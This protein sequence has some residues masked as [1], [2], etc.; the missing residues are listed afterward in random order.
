MQNSFTHERVGFQLFPPLTIVDDL[1]R[2]NHFFDLIVV[3]YPSLLD[4][5]D[6]TLSFVV[7]LETSHVP[8]DG[9]YFREF[10]FR[11]SIHTRK[12]VSTLSAIIRG[13]FPSRIWDLSDSK[14][15]PREIEDTQLEF[16]ENNKIRG[17]NEHR[18]G[19]RICAFCF[20]RIYPSCPVLCE[21]CSRRSYCSIECMHRDSDPTGEG[22]GHSIWCS[23]NVCEEGE[24]WTV[25][26]VPGKGLGV[27]AKKFIASR[28]RILVDKPRTITFR[29]VRDLEPLEGPLYRK[30]R[31]NS[32]GVSESESLLCLRVAR[33][34]HDC[35]P[36]ASQVFDADMG[37]M[38]VVANR[39]IAAEE[40]ICISYLNSLGRNGSY[41]L[42]SG[43]SLLMEKWGIRCPPNCGCY[44]SKFQ[45]LIRNCRNL[46]SEIRDI[47]ADRIVTDVSTRIEQLSH[48][49]DTLQVAWAWKGDLLWDVFEYTHSTIFTDGSKT[50]EWGRMALEIIESVFHPSS[51]RVIEM[52]ALIQNAH[53]YDASSSRIAAQSA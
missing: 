22:Q 35:R 41:D 21:R 36:N 26:P 33:I 29:A 30:E 48:V 31:L 14:Y 49:L 27:V 15:T 4:D 1:I 13:F 50:W 42:E 28:S 47:I 12:L 40:E 8:R 10:S 25:K 46:D 5:A 38:I 7:D 3:F 24:D 19:T 45:S 18:Q 9:F 32:F 6:T 2:W 43:R 11:S 53:S 16:R 51:G 34:N 23:L 37:V 20:D 44:D 39:D 52:Q 17:R